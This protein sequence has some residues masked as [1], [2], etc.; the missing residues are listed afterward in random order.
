[1]IYC[2]MD[3]SLKETYNA[4]E[5]LLSVIE[6]LSGA[7]AQNVVPGRNFT[8]NPANTNIGV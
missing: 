6:R 8:Y 1:M 7:I 5:T 2:N 3:V 4:A